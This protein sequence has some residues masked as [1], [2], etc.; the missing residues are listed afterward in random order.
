[1]LLTC[2]P[3]SIE[4]F[5]KQHGWSIVGATSSASLTIRYRSQIELTFQPARFANATGP[6]SGMS[7]GPIK[8]SFCGSDI[9]TTQR[10]FLQS[11]QA[12]LQ[13]MPQRSTLIAS[14]LQTIGEGWTASVDIGKSE[15]SLRIEG[16]IE[17][18]IKSDECLALTTTILLPRIRTKVRVIFL[19]SVMIDDDLSIDISTT[20]DIQVV[21]GKVPKL[22]SIKDSLSSYARQG[23]DTWQ[24]GLQWLQKEMMTER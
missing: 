13:A 3:A 19:A 8:L 23:A 9:T 10:F 21:Y 17:T 2:F 14:M 1:M 24:R 20:G 15:Q 6:D 12:Y 11:L 5:E 22:D 18:S 7:N 16:H 4:D